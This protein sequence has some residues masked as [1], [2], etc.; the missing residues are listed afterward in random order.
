MCIYTPLFIFIEKPSSPIYYEAL[1]RITPGH[2]NISHFTSTRQMPSGTTELTA[3]DILLAYYSDISAFEH[4][5]FLNAPFSHPPLLY[6]P[7]P[8]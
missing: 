6:T 7:Y 4:N 2:T 1:Y 8:Y 3:D 5:L